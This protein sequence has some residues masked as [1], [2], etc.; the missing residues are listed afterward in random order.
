[1]TLCVSCDSWDNRVLD[2]RKQP[3][4]GWITRRRECMICNTRWTTYEV[5]SKDVKPEAPH[6]SPP[7]T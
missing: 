2:S 3:A 1:M 7:E 5:P 6:E 4:T